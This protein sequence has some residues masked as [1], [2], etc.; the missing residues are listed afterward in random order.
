MESLFFNLERTHYKRTLLWD[1]EEGTVERI[2]ISNGMVLLHGKLHKGR[3]RFEA[4]YIDAAAMVAAV[5]EGEIHTITPSGKRAIVPEGMSALYASGRTTFTLE[6]RAKRRCD[7]FVLFCADFFLA[8]Y[9]SE[10]EDDPVDRLSK[11]IKNA[12]ACDM[13]DTLPLD[14]LSEYLVQRIID[15]ERFVTMRS[16]RAEI[17]AAEYLT[18]R[19]ELWDVSREGVAREER[20]IAARAKAILLKRFVDPPSLEELAH[21]CA[22]NTAR[23][24]KVFKS[25]YGMTVYAYV[26]RLRMQEAMYLLTHEHLQV[27]EVA[28]RVGYRHKGHFSKRFFETFGISPKDARQTAFAEKSFT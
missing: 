27:G 14:P 1:G 13:L 23:L 18:R 9:L 16:F 10:K 20:T 24:K 25:T 2:D 7:A 12:G 5:S 3:Y 8:R 28:V 11:L 17:T 26:R 15:A 22:T 21:M 6:W 4:D 19:L